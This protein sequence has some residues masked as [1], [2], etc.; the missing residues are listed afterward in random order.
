[1]KKVLLRDAAKCMA[2]LEPFM[3]VISNN[4]H[5]NDSSGL[6]RELYL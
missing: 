3:A 2:V 4:Q 5:V 1:M 6:K